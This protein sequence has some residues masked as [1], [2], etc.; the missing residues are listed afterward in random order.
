MKPFSLLFLLL[1]S[2]SSAQTLPLVVEQSSSDRALYEGSAENFLVSAQGKMAAL[3]AQR[4]FDKGGNIIDAAIAASFVISV[5]RPQSTGIGGGGFLLFHEAKT[6]KTYA[7]DFRER[8]PLRAT[9]NMFLGKDGS[10]IPNLSTDGILS[11]AVPGLV[12]GLTEIHQKFGKLKLSEVVAPAIDLA[13]NG[14][15]VY[16]GLAKSLQ[17]KKEVLAQFP[18]SAAIFLKKDG[19]PYR[20]G[21]KLVQ[22]NLAQ[23]LRLIAAEGKKA[24]YNGKITQE[25]LAESKHRGG[26]L[27]QKDFDAYQVKW[28]EPLRGSYK[29]YELLAMP[30]PSSGG[31]HVLEIL[32][33]LEQDDLKKLGVL[34]AESIHRTAA[35]MQLAFA[36]RSEYPGDPDFVK[37]PAERLISKSYA[38][39]LR[40]KIGDRA[41]SSSSIKPGL[42]PRQE[43]FETTHFSIMDK[44]GNSVASTQTINL[45]FGSSLVAGKSGILLNDEMDD[46]SAKPGVANAFGAL[47][48]EANAI[49]PQKTPLSSM[50]P[51]IVL[52]DGI[53][54]MT[55]GAPGGTRILTCVAQTILN[56]LEYKLPIYEAVAVPRFHHQWMPDRIDIDL[57]GPGEKT[58]SQLRAKGYTLNLGDD[59]VSC[60]V[61]A[62]VRE[63]NVLRGAADPRDLGAVLGR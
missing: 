33:I 41:N 22:K 53:P 39:T 11:V 51:T 37:V 27:Q 3:A 25:I 49:A 5:E 47:G 46:F 57:P 61:E 40:T 63:G 29:G 8:A 43:S 18:T 21:E 6:G 23:S 62:V 32:N 58:L 9:R 1:F 36:D 14:L 42:G 48:G 19:S 15:E 7:V 26:L 54:I 13:E 17:Q 55:V 38:A 10:V 16:P 44:E 12:A 2:C 35:A 20:V 59:A 28:R 50:S 31:I 30:P 60:R 4:M 56:Y 52:K 45:Y 24:F 34:S